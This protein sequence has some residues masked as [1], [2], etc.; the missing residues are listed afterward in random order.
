MKKIKNNKKLYSQLSGITVDEINRKRLVN[1]IKKLN[2]QDKNFLKAI[3]EIDRVR[4]FI[5]A[6]E[7]IIGNKSTKHGEIAEHV[8]VGIRRARQVLDGKNMTATFEGV[9]RIAPEDYLID[10]IKV[11]SKFINGTKNNLDAVLKHMNKYSD[12]GRDNSYY[13]IPKDEY[14]L[15]EMILNGEKNIDGL[16]LKTI[17]T[18][19]RKIYE[20]ENKSGKSFNEIVK[21]ALSKYPEVQ[22]GKVHSTLDQHEKK[23]FEKNEQKKTQ[24]SDEHKPNM[25]DALK[26]TG[27]AAAVGATVSLTTSLYIKSKEGKY[28]YKGDFTIDDW[29]DVGIDVLKGGSIGGV[30]GASIYTLTNY[31]SLSA[32]FA[33]AIVSASKGVGVLANDLKKGKIDKYEFIE[34]GM[35]ICAESA[36]VGLATV[37]G[38]TVIPIPIL[39][40]V[41]GSFAGT[42]L[43]NSL[44]DKNKVTG[45]Q[46]QSDIDD[47]I[48]KLDKSYQNLINEITLEFKNLGGLTEACFNAKNNKETFELSI[49]LALAYGIKNEDILKTNDD[50]DYYMK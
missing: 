46:I 10:G 34:L 14:N 23:V 50:I 45:K 22:Q 27:V 12:F 16:K 8:E 4:E 32:P 47:Y 24:I 21:P 6:P 38:Q 44:G 5:G 31:A 11:Q 20:I 30:S 25:T 7:K 26:A 43:T 1:E 41:V 15:I 19:K 40:A 36:I 35:V 29:K 13:H 2:I 48:K 39:G 17:E 28:F 3:E 37:A 9:S 33:G 49:Q 18:I 42:I